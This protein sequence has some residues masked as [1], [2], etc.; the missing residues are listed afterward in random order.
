MGTNGGMM[1]TTTITPSV[2]QVAQ[3]KQEEQEGQNLLKQ[4]Q[5]EKLTCATLT[6]DNF[7]KIGDYVMRQRVCNLSSTIATIVRKVCR[8]LSINGSVLRKGVVRKVCRFFDF[9]SIPLPRKQN[10]FS[11]EIVVVLPVLPVLA[12]NFL[13]RNGKPWVLT[14]PC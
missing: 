13:W 14:Q 3:I 5:A 1:G 4:V 10:I 11:Y 12:A 6:P 2:Q 8:Q 7:E 9:G